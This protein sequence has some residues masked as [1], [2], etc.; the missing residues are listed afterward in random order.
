MDPSA[1]DKACP[2]C[3]QLVPIASGSCPACGHSFAQE[4]GELPPILAESGE[5]SRRPRRGVVIAVALAV[6]LAG[7]GLAAFIVPVSQRAAVPGV[8]VTIG[9]SE[10]ILEA[11]APRACVRTVLRYLPGLLRLTKR[12]GDVGAAFFEVS[13]EIGFDSPGY[14]ALVRVYAAPKV[15][16]ALFERGLRAAVRAARLLARAA[17]RG[18]L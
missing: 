8:R 3:G 1:G 16:R 9:E 15:Q 6:L 11:V 5:P 14:T 7:L 12:G 18:E 13:E 4:I 2:S 10:A 17:C